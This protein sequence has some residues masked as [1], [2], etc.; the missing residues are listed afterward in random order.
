ML[1]REKEQENKT[2]EKNASTTVQQ[3]ACRS[4]SLGTY[5]HLRRCFTNHDA[6]RVKCNNDSLY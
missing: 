1:N 4:R 3:E 2:I 5:N 6:I